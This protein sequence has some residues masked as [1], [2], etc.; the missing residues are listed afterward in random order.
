[1]VVCA[2]RPPPSVNPVAGAAAAVVVALKVSPVAAGCGVARLKAGVGVPNEK[3]PLAAVLFA[4]VP[5]LNP[6]PG[7]APPWAGCAGAAVPNEKPPPGTTGVEVAMPKAV[8]GAA[9]AAVLDPND[10]K[11]APAAAAAAV[12][13]PKLKPPPLIL[14]SDST[15]PTEAVTCCYPRVAFGGATRGVFGNRSTS[16]NV[17]TATTLP[18]RRVEQ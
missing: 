7:L 16:L 15:V 13:W 1:M 17:C 12:G 11:G 5:K 6:P 3:P 9:A 2:A 4:G 8:A 18:T 10:P 14:W